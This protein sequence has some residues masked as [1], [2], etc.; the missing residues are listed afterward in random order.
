MQFQDSGANSKAR[1]GLLD[2]FPVDDDKVWVQLR[3]W[4]ER[5]GASEL[6][7]AER[8]VPPAFVQDIGNAWFM[9]AA[10]YISETSGAPA[11]LSAVLPLQAAAAGS[12]CFAAFI[13]CFLD[14]LFIC[15]KPELRLKLRNLRR[16]IPLAACDEAILNSIICSRSY[17]VTRPR[18]EISGEHPSGGMLRLL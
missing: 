17:S 12:S 18:C 11:R 8:I 5:A 15:G 1:M 4:G 13:S 3:G 2:T 16:R 10:K 6:P 7:K 9:S 14:G